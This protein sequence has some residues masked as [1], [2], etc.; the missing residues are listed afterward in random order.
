M[1]VRLMVK[2]ILNFPMATLRKHLWLKVLV[3]KIIL[4]KKVIL[5][6]LRRNSF[7]NAVIHS[8]QQSHIFSDDQ[9]LRF[10][11]FCIG[12]VFSDWL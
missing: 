7:Y 12:C 3:R 9:R 8:L 4:K 1:C 2:I 11:R 5:S 6:F 10:K